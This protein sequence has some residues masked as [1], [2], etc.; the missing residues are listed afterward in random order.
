MSTTIIMYSVFLILFAG[1]F[2][3]KGRQ[4]VAMVSATLVASDT[5]GVAGGCR[6]T[7]VA[8]APRS[9][10][11]GRPPVR[12]AGALFQGAPLRWRAHRVAPSAKRADRLGTRKRGVCTDVA[13]REKD[14]H[15]PV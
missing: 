14:P 11:A 9:Q 12:T 6:A 13:T 2:L 8:V 4:W 7:C 3:P 5:R 1:A 10:T 15:G